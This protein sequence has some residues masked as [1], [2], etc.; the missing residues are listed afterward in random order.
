YEL[1]MERFRNPR[2]VDLWTGV[3]DLGYTSAKGNT[4]TVT[5]SSTANATRST[6]RDKIA[7]F[8]TSIYSR[9]DTSG[10]SL[11]TA[12]T[13]RGGV[14]YS[15]NV[16]PKAFVF[17]SVD[18]EFDEFQGL[19]LRFVPAAG[20]GWHAVKNDRTTFD[21]FTGASMNREFFVTGL[22][23]TS[24][25]VLLGNE[26]VHKIN[27]TLSFRERLVVYPNFTDTGS[28]RINFDT[29]L[30]AALRQWLALQVSLSDRFLSNPL[31]GRKKNDVIIT[32]GVRLTFAR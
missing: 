19:D 14:N 13:I 24:G 20:V 15:L 27:S 26:L 10:V 8:F 17:G 22:S 21:V 16:S 4:E 6:S 28:F 30:A 5:L 9:N 29:S 11:L 3:V 7:V 12:N 1:E 25:E 32:T 31:P 2:V 18:L 23:R